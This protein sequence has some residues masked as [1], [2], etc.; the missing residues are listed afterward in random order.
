M[1]FRAGGWWFDSERRGGGSIQS[2]G[3]VVRFRAGGWWFGSTQS[4]G[5]GGSIQ[6]DV[7]KAGSN[8]RGLSDHLPLYFLFRLLSVEEEHA[9]RRDYAVGGDDQ[10]AD[11][12]RLRDA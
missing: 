7:I 5:G 10:V 6:S 9:H 1:R 12:L 2:G 3:L 4:G 8:S 11:A